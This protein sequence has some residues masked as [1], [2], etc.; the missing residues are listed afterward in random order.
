MSQLMTPDQR[1]LK[2]ES[3]ILARLVGAPGNALLGWALRRMKDCGIK[4]ECADLLCSS[5]AAMLRVATATEALHVANATLACAEQSDSKFFESKHMEWIR[6]HS[7]IAGLN[8]NLALLNSWGI[9]I[10]EQ[11]GTNTQSWATQ[12]LRNRRLGSA[13]NFETL[14]EDRLFYWQRKALQYNLDGVSVGYLKVFVPID[15][16]SV[17]QRISCLASSSAPLLAIAVLRTVANAWCCEARFGVRGTHCR[18][19]C[20]SGED[21][22]THYLVCPVLM[23]PIR[24]LV[25]RSTRRDA[26]AWPEYIMLAAEDV[27]YS[28]DGIVLAGIACNTALSVYN[29]VRCGSAS[30]ADN[31]AQARLRFLAKVDA[32]IRAALGRIE[33]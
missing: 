10:N 3:H 4:L 16:K 12:I 5:R 21:N 17:I 9:T 19:G 11:V 8:R 25:P 18:L 26:T 24:R 23:D 33:S 20:R 27:C 30:D 32:R 13:Q 22:L 31:L 1:M 2:A 15:A 14:I 7:I 29:A 28:E 6:E